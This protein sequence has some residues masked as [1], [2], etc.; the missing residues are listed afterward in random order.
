MALVEASRRAL[1]VAKVSLRMA[2]ERRA[3]GTAALLEVDRA[4]AELESD[5]QQLAGGAEL[6]VSIVAR[7]LQSL[8]GRE[9]A[10]ELGRA[11][12]LADDLHEE[13][14]LERFE[15]PDERIPSLLAARQSRV[16][17]EQLAAAQRLSLVPSLAGIP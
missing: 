11:G 13:G 5:F 14:P 7:A 15:A 8:T 17:A 9:I 2:D 1:E 16:S 10:P 12:P 6:Q 3:A 4:R